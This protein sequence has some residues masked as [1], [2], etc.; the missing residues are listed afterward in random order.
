MVMLLKLLILYGL[1]SIGRIDIHYGKIIVE[2]KNEA[3]GKTI[4]PIFEREKISVLNDIDDGI[5]DYSVTHNLSKKQSAGKLQAEKFS[6]ADN[7][8]YLQGNEAAKEKI[9]AQL[10]VITN[11]RV[12]N[13]NLRT[14]KPQMKVDDGNNMII[15]DLDQDD[16]R[17][18]SILSNGTQEI[19][20][21]AEKSI[22]KEEEPEISEDNN[23][24]NVPKTV[25]KK[26]K[27]LKELFKTNTVD[28]RMNDERNDESG[29]RSDKHIPEESKN[30]TNNLTTQ[31]KAIGILFNLYSILI[32]LSLKSLMTSF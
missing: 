1:L 9:A 12:K 28:T 8:S 21:Y 32:S 11:N 5:T 29:N 13:S 6:E 27:S 18:V 22:E 15:G 20:I 24:P 23:F 4:Y 14:Q 7:V 3:P 16:I 31:E 17:E 25:F 2:G 30:R 19:I 10:T 26:G